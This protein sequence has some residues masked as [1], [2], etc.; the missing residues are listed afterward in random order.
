MV[1][2]RYDCALIYV[3]DGT[4]LSL[5]PQYYLPGYGMVVG[6]TNYSYGMV[7]VVKRLDQSSESAVDTVRSRL[8]TLARRAI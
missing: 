1:W 2:Y 4:A 7:V 8:A 6:T 3:D 5:D